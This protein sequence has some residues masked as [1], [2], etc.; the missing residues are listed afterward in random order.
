LDETPQPK[1]D[2]SPVWALHAGSQYDGNEY[3]ALPVE[4]VRIRYQWHNDIPLEPD[5]LIRDK[6]AITTT[7]FLAPDRR[8]SRARLGS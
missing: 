6:S 2:A 4:V 3:A 5:R 1:S 8:F 7:A